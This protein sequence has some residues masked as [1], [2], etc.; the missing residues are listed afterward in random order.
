MAA[1]DVAVALARSVRDYS[2]ELHLARRCSSDVLQVFRCF[3]SWLQLGANSVAPAQLAA[4]PLVGAS[5]DALASPQ[6]FDSAVDSGPRGPARPH[7]WPVLGT[8]FVLL[9]CGAHE[10]RDFA[11]LMDEPQRSAVVS[12]TVCDRHCPP[13]WLPN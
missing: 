6:L 12:S 1:F 5:F 7:T 11:L 4:N 9:R 2:G 13:H 10:C 3:V 8:A